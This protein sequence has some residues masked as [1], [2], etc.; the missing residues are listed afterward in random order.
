LRPREHPTE[1]RGAAF[2]SKR[3][4][5]EIDREKQVCPWVRARGRLIFDR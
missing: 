2:M 5:G 3:A 4:A 1:R